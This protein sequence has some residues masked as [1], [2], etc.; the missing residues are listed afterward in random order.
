MENESDHPADAYLSQPLKHPTS[1]K[2]FE[3]QVE[4]ALKDKEKGDRKIPTK[5]QETMLS[6]R[7]LAESGQSVSQ[8][9]SKPPIYPNAKNPKSNFLR[10][11]K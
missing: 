10:L 3:Q 4:L 9:L 5:K 2:S 11:I 1:L 7:S 6:K 8:V